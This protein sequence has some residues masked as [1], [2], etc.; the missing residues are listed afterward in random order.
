MSTKARNKLVKSANFLSKFDDGSNIC[1]KTLLKAGNLTFKST[2][3]NK[4]TSLDFDL[5][6]NG[7]KH[8]N[9]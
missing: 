4:N 5:Y 8:C 3:I 7:Y 2:Q 6:L 9:L 1:N